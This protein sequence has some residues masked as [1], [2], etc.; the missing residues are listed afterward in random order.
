MAEALGIA[1][2]VGGFVSLAKDIVDMGIELRR[3]YKDVQE[4]DKTLGE[5]IMAVEANLQPVRGLLDLKHKQLA[6]DFTT[7]SALGTSLYSCQARLTI[8]KGKLSVVH[9]DLEKIGRTTAV[10]KRTFR[11]L[12]WPFQAESFKQELEDIRQYSLI[13]Q[14]ALSVD[15]FTLLSRTVLDVT[16]ILR[17]QRQ[18]SN[19]FDSLYQTFSSMNALSVDIRGIKSWNQE[20]VRKEKIAQRSRALDWLSEH[21]MLQKHSDILSKRHGSTGNWIVEQDSVQKWLQGGATPKIIWCNGG[22]G[23][24]KT[25]ASAIVME[26]LRSDKL[27]TSGGLNALAFAICD[28]QDPETQSALAIL[29]AI[30]KQLFQYLPESDYAWDTIVKMS[31]DAS[32]AQRK[33]SISQINDLLLT[34]AK[35]FSSVHVVV[36]GVDEMGDKDER[37]NMLERLLEFIGC[38]SGVILFATSRPNFDDIARAFRGAETVSLTAQKDDIRRYVQHYLNRDSSFSDRLTSHEDLKQ[39]IERQIVDQCA[40]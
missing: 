27:K 40:G 18:I 14:F 26:E 19:N 4:A 17:N 20:Q 22:P 38:G 34:L 1:A 36:D 8:L 7:T 2:A 13:F 10:F 21:K 3:Y 31:D 37:R 15:G 29:A 6:A 30:A 24:G 5:I 25:M 39:R 12:K 35:S 33:P 16:E 32:K 23:I 11:R 9:R 28:S